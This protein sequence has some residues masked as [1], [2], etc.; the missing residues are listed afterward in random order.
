MISNC[1]G[2]WSLLLSSWNTHYLADL[3]SV[4]KLDPQDLEYP[5]GSSETSDVE[6]VGLTLDALVLH[7]CY[8]YLDLHESKHRLRTRSCIRLNLK[9]RYH[10]ARIAPVSFSAAPMA[11]LYISCPFVWLHFNALTL[12]IDSLGGQAM[13]SHGSLTCFKCLAGRANTLKL[14]N[15]RLFFRPSRNSF[16][17][18]SRISEQCQDNQCKY[19]AI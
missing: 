10:P 3:F 17:R 7:A 13:V 4:D 8:I 6:K 1:R 16:R 15:L 5:D 18:D 9:Q 12:A 14:S 11:L 2:P 19:D